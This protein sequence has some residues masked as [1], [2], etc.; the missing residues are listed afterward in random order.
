[1]SNFKDCCSDYFENVGKFFYV[2]LEEI[3]NVKNIKKIKQTKK[4]HNERMKKKKTLSV[5]FSD[6]KKSPQFQLVYA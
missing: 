4:Y 5:M 2:F 6:Y 1:M 3:K